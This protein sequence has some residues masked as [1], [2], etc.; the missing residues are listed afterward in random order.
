MPLVIS[1]QAMLVRL[2]HRHPYFPG[3]VNYLEFLLL[4]TM[5][6]ISKDDV[7]VIFDI[8]DEDGSGES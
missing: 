8:V 4:L 7:A 2:V 3:N 5:V 6:S 1:Q